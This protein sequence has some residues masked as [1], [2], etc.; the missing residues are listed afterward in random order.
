MN[1]FSKFFNKRNL[2]NIIFVFSMGFIVR[3][4]I[5]NFNININTDT[6][7][8]YII[9]I[10]Y[11]SNLP[12]FS[13]ILK[14]DLSLFTLNNLKFFIQSLFSKYNSE[15]MLNYTNIVSNINDI[16][17]NKTTFY[18][19]SNRNIKHTNNSQGYQYYLQNRFLTRKI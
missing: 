15:V 13:T 1:F 16:N 12:S 7:V 18:T 2:I 6:I 8:V 5:N 10:N 11:L 17:I 19:N 9:Y 4:F 3:F 14:I